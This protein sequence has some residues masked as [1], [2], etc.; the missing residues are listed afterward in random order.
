[1]TG[2]EHYLREL[3]EVDREILHYAVAC[4]VDV[5]DRAAVQACLA[6]HHDTWAE[7][8][9]RQ[10]LRGLLQLRLRIETEMLELGMRPPALASAGQ[11]HQY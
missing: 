10:S 11:E 3:A 8:R 6:E 4:R 1:M 2:F 5:A 7:D 9:A